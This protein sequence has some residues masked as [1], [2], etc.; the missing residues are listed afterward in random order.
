MFTIEKIIKRFMDVP[1]EIWWRSLS[2]VLSAFFLVPNITL[3]MF[4]IYMAEHN[5]FSYDLIID[6]IFG[7][8]LFFMTTVLMLIFM[9]VILYS[10]ILIFFARK[11]AIKIDKSVYWSAGLSSVTT[12]LIF[13]GTSLSSGDSGK[14]VFAFLICTLI[15]IHIIILLFYK[16]R[17][18]FISL[19]GITFSVIFLSINF[20][21]QSSKV[22]SIGLQVFGVG[23]DLPVTISS[24][25]SGSRK[26][27]KLKLITPKNIY[28]SPEDED[29]VATY[30][31]SNV[32]YYIVGKK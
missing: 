3:I 30:S 25:Q 4:L 28:F 17:A 10:P 7:M 5:F 23:G 32:G 14:V 13:V 8:K 2:Y 29:G 31:L 27:G 16:A 19:A 11:K 22:I 26:K 9:A 24:A 18:Q 20:P 12:W 1:S 6:G 15:I 21:V